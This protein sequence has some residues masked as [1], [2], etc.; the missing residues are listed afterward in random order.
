MVCILEYLFNY[1]II[2]ELCYVY[3]DVMSNRK[4]LKLLLTKKGIVN[5]DM[6]ED[7]LE[8]I[9]LV[10]SKPLNHYNIIFM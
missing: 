4:I 3:L 5:C 2:I 10:T 8:C 9:E 6:V 1:F 7:G